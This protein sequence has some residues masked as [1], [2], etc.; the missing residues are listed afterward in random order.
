MREGESGSNLRFYGA[1]FGERFSTSSCRLRRGFRVAN[2]PNSRVPRCTLIKG[3]SSVEI[4]VD[5][6]LLRQLPEELKQ[7]VDLG[8]AGHSKNRSKKL[9][10]GHVEVLLLTLRQCS[11]NAPGEA[12]RG[13]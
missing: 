5:R 9:S 6:S 1:C 11:H 3:S 7:V 10:T 2:K 13:T 12:Y 4:R 8:S